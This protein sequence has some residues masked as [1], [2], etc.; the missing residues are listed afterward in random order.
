MSP[1]SLISSS[2]SLVH[3]RVIADM[4]QRSLPVLDTGKLTCFL[5]FLQEFLGS[6]FLSQ[7]RYFLIFGEKWRLAEVISIMIP[8]WLSNL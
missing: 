3:L 7:V 6:S 4:V 8:E 5:L 2:V 1:L